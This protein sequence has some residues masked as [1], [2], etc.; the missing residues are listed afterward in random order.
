MSA[1]RPPVRLPTRPAGRRGR[2]VPVLVVVV[3]AFVAFF[4]MASVWTSKLWFDTLG[5]GEVFSTSLLTRIALFA[6]GAVLTFA[7]LAGTGTIEADGTVGGILGI[8]QKLYGA[9]DGGASV[10]LAPA[11]DCDE[12]KGV[13]IDGL[14]VYRVATLNDSVT[15]LRD[16]DAGRPPSVPRCG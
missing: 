2:L 15:V 11:S 8:Q 5:A 16:L 9:R 13:H 3:V 1:I 12:A 7:V 10:F 6:I 4:T 14:S